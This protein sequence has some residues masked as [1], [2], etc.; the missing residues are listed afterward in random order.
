VQFHAIPRELYGVPSRIWFDAGYA[1]L[2][3]A[4][5]GLLIRHFRE[6]LAVV[7]ANPLGKG[8]LLYLVLLW[9][10]V[11]GNLMH[12]IPP[13]GAERLITEGVIH[14][15][16]VCCTVLILLWPVRLPR[17]D[18]EEKPIAGRSLLVVAGVGILA[19][20]LVTGVASW[21]TRAIHGEEFVGHAGYHVRFGPKALPPHPKRGE[22]HP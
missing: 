18:V 20:A 15:N 9:W 19:L 10:V 2:A 16:A 8:Q 13:F 11:V 17:P 21:G 6:P 12:A 7:P 5:L 14:L 4:V 1:V 22:V 3:A